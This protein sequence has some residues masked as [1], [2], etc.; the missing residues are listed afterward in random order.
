MK[1]IHL[2]PENLLQMP[3]V[4]MVQNWYMQSFK[5]ILEFQDMEPEDA[6]MLNK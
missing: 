1:E 6:A 3:S 5:E 4:S 2:L